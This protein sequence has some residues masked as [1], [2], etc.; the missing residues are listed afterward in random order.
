MK[1]S[2]EFLKA[3]QMAFY[4]QQYRELPGVK[5]EPMDSDETMEEIDSFKF[6]MNEYRKLDNSPKDYDPRSGHLLLPE[7]HCIGRAL[8]IN[9]QGD[10]KEGR[11]SRVFVD[12]PRGGFQEDHFIMA[13]DT[14]HSLNVRPSSD[15][16]WWLEAFHWNRSD[17]ERAQQQLLRICGKEKQPKTASD[18]VKILAA[19]LSDL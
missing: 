5:K 15:R 10:H 4:F 3:R 12:E 17:P 8:Q 7:E 18:P 6:L 14:F 13:G 9:Y 2:T 16:D 1:V 11:I 19:Q